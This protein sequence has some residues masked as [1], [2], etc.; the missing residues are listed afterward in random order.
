M[1]A[2]DRLVPGVTTVTLNARY[3]PLHGLIAAEAQKRNL[4]LSAAQDLM[5]RAEVAI[6]AVS[7]RHLHVDPVPHGVLSRP[8]GYDVIVPQVHAGSVDLGALAAPRV[9]AQPSWGFWS[10]YRGSEAVLQIVG[11]HEFAPGEQFDAAAVREGLG[12]LLSLADLRTL[13][14]DALDDNAHLCICRSAGNPDGAWLARLFAQP[15][16]SDDRQTRAWTR[17][18]TLRIVARCVELTSVRQLS[19]DV[20]RFLAFG[21]AVTEDRVLADTVV[22]ARWRGVILRNH[23]VGAWRGLWAWMVNGIDGLTLRTVL[24]DRFAAALPSQTV[25]VFS[26]GLPATRTADGRPA[27]AELDPDLMESD[28][29]VWGLGV[30][31]LG[32]RRSRELTG[33]E[34]SGFQGD[35]PEDIF[36]EL[37]PAWLARQAEMWHDQPVRDFARWLAEVM[38]NRSQR[39]ALRKARPD[40]RTGVLKIPSRVHLRDRFIFRDSAEGGG[41]ASL[42]LDQL[43]GVLA[44]V[45]LLARDDDTWVIGPRGDL[46]A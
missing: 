14:T 16:I 12:D 43:A 6:G 5:R 18:Q 44:G 17:R 28:W 36:E 32:A 31:L 8:H 40:P 29:P 38:V 33:H 13:G 4:N 26:G 10:A 7:A 3:Y 30:L 34:L 42:R 11:T 24:G 45:G 41:Q 22:S 23:S 19:S 35:D 1:N 39:L 27:P 21:G 20:S 37:S 9:Y 46:L 25:G 15:G 2:V